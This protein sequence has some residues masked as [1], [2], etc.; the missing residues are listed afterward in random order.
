MTEP[1]TEQTPVLER[2]PVDGPCPRCGAEELRRYHV[3]AEPGWLEVVKC[4]TCLFSV[5]RKPWNRLGPIQLLV[6]LI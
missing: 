1:N 6:D 4:Q 3:V 5:E 2:T